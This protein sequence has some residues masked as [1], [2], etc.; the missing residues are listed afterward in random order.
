MKLEKKDILTPLDYKNELLTLYKSNHLDIALKKSIFYLKGNGTDVWLLNFVGTV[1]FKLSNFKNAISYYDKILAIDD[2]HFDALNNKGL[3]FNKLGDFKQAIKIFQKLLKL[4]YNK[5]YIVLNNLGATLKNLGNIEKSIEI[6]KISIQLNPNYLNSYN[7]LGIS[8]LDKNDL[9]NAEYYFNQGLFIKNDSPEI[10]NNLGKVYLI[11]KKYEKAYEFYLKS[12]S[13]NENDISVWGNLAICLL[14][15][16][17][18]FYNKNQESLFLQILNKNVQENPRK[19]ALKALQLLKLNPEFKNLMTKQFPLKIKDSVCLKELANNKLFLRILEVAPLSDLEIEKFLI[20]ARKFILFNLSNLLSDTKLLSFLISLAKQC[21]TNEYIYKVTENEEKLLL[22]LVNNIKSKIKKGTYIDP[23][24][25]ACIA[26]YQKLY[27]F[28]IF[29]PDFFNS[30]IQLLII[31]QIKNVQDEK[32]IEKEIYEVVNIKD[33]ISK[34][35]KQQYEENPYP[36]W[37]EYIQPISYNSLKNY[38]KNSDLKFDSELLYNDYPKQIL[39]AGCGTGKQAID[40]AL[41][42]KNAEITA[43][44]LSK[45]SLSYAIRKSKEI[46]I[47]NINFKMCDINNVD[48]LNKSFDIIECVGV[49]HHMKNPF[50]GWKK[51]SS[52]LN[53][54]GLMFVGLY[55]EI[56]RRNIS[57][58]RKI[59]KRLNILPTKTNIIKFRNDLIYNDKKRC[60]NF[61]YWSDF[62]NFS[63][64]RDLFFHVQEHCFSISK[65]KNY[66]HRLGFNFCGFENDK[67]KI[68]FLINNKNSDLFDLEKWEEFEINNKDVFSEMY[69]FWIQKIKGN[70]SE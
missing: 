33:K 38:L 14:K 20:E 10:F 37:T 19:I 8:Y 48:L 59:I 44:D 57:S 50:M 39:I 29:K 56:A 27:D 58:M 34:L 4:N 24:E 15:M 69:Q 51:L 49:L 68:E 6:L 7:N 63:E 22:K 21:F 11:K 70:L 54:G 1:N 43:I 28:N 35:V 5:N 64:F 18:F 3:A 2:K 17:L 55:S 62:Y 66:I 47:T 41:T 32:E 53:H 30:K 26:C 67:A 52:I 45:A 13:L 42:F 65:I 61:A 16:D 40:T 12:I 46:G 31:E 9:E 36:K 60:E 25:I 23:I